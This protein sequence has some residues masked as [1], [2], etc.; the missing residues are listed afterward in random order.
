MLAQVLLPDNAVMKGTCLQGSASGSPF[1]YKLKQ[2]GEY[3]YQ[4]LGIIGGTL[5]LISHL[6]AQIVTY[7]FSGAVGNETNYAADDQPTGAVASVFS[8]GSGINPAAGADAFSAKA[9]TTGEL[10][11]NEYFTFS[12][13]PDSGYEMSLSELQLDERRSGTGIRDWLVRSSLDG[14]VSNIGAVFSVP[15]SL[16]TRTDQSIS[17]AGGTF[18]QI[19]GPVEFRIYGFN[20]ESA[21]G[22]WRVDDVEVFGTLTPVPEVSSAYW[23]AGSLLGFSIW[24]GRSKSVRQQANFRGTT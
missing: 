18:D 8:R 14:F 23:V 12:L 2:K 21:A 5:L 1:G 22:T 3:M 20:A 13:T 9:W 24:R 4:T 6:N 10:D 19:G 15:D 16:A 17:L 11:A 7:S